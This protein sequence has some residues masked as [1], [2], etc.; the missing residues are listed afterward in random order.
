M[1][2]AWADS[3]ALLAG[4]AQWSTELSERALRDDTQLAELAAELAQSHGERLDLATDAILVVLLCG[5]T[6]VGKSTLINALA[7]AEISRPGLGATTSAAVIYLHEDDNPERLFEYGKEIG[8]LARAPQTIVRHRRPELL[9][10]VLIDTPDIDSVVRDH[11][12]LTGALV[13]AADLVLFVTTP[14]R[15]RDMQAAQWVEEQSAQRAMAFVLNKWDRASLG[16]QWTE[17]ARVE[18]DFRRVLAGNGFTASQIFKV[19]CVTTTGDERD[20][21]GAGE[22]DLPALRDWLARGLDRSASAAIQD[23]RRVGAWGRLAAA[24]TTNIPSPISDAPWVKEAF[25]VFASV[26]QQAVAPIRITAIEVASALGERSVWPASPGLFGTYG[27]FLAWCAALRQNPW[28]NPFGFGRSPA[29]DAHDG[30]TDA[31][32]APAAFGAALP[33]LLADAVRAL[34]YRRI[35]HSLPLKVV[36][37]QWDNELASVPER[38][39]ALPAATLADVVANASALSFRRACGIVAIAA[40]ELAILAVLGFAMWQVGLGFVTGQ[41]ASSGLIYSTAT[42]VILLLL[43]GHMLANFFFPSLRKRFQA[44][45]TGRLQAG[46]EHSCGRME[47]ALHEHVTAIDRLAAQGRDVQGAIDRCVQSLR[48]NADGAA[49]DRLFGRKAVAMPAVAENATPASPVSPPRRT[50]KFE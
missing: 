12:A 1:S 8:E 32:A 50:P 33:A 14:E 38:I 18:H 2:A 28:Y 22:N 7:D 21:N 13:H 17:R 24:V 5:P 16:L 42:L 46:I 15:Y 47:A 48:R 30:T 19:S 37:A 26:R 11:R 40:I 10:K 27:R 23:R 45:L 43:A 39:A 3:G 35:A 6:A 49:I 25:E 41:Y 4:I 29:A 36:D 20:G 44:E 9:H 34:R 31:P